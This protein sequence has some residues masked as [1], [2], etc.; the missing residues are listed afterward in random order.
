MA[1]SAR[2]YALSGKQAL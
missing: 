1:A 2:R